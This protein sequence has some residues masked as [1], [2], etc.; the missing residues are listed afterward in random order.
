VKTYGVVAAVGLLLGIAM[1]WWVEPETNAGAVFIVV[2]TALVCFVANV[3]LTAI[4]G[5]FS[6]RHR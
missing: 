4:G 5:L 3:V 6:K 1:V 2:A